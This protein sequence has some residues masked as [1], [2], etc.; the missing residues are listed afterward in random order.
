MDALTKQQ[1]YYLKN[2]EQV[3]ERVYLKRNK[4]MPSPPVVETTPPVV[5]TTE[6]IPKMKIITVRWD[7]T[8]KVLH[9][10]KYCI[11]LAEF[12]D[13]VIGYLKWKGYKEI[14]HYI[15]ED[16][17]LVKEYNQ[18]YRV[19]TVVETPPKLPPKKKIMILRVIDDTI[20]VLHRKKFKFV[21]KD[22]MKRVSFLHWL[23]GYDKVMAQFSAA[24]PAYKDHRAD[25]G[26]EEIYTLSCEKCRLP[27]HPV[28]N[29]EDHSKCYDCYTRK[30]PRNCC[31]I[32]ISKLKIR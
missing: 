5:E 8:A 32:N 6:F 29:N 20:K 18:M 12:S 16:N 9:R 28:K 4:P 23:Q 13:K 21:L 7:D 11:V 30:V 31:L 19:E 1:R 17:D 2:K 10:K 14:I 22:L 26:F 15:D 24:A 25:K 3:K 27:F